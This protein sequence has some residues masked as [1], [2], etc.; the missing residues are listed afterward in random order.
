MFVRHNTFDWQDPADFAFEPSPVWLDDDAMAVDGGSQTFL[1]NILLKSKSSLGDYRKEC[2]QKRKEVENAKRLRQSIRE[3]RDKRD[4]VEVVR[5]QFALQERLHECERQKITAEVEVSTIATVVGDLSIG[6][7]NHAFKSQ[8][9]KIPTNCDLCGERIWGLSAKGFDCKD[10][11]FTCHNKCE[12]KVPASC[13]GEVGKEDRKKLKVERQAS[14]QA[15]TPTQP[16]QNGDG[17]SDM[18]TIS[19]SDTVGSMNT[20]SSGFATSA[21]RSVSGTIKGPEEAPKVVATSGSRRRV[22]APPPDHYVSNGTNGASKSE[23]HGKMT[24]AYQQN[25]DGEISV[26]E[27]NEVTILEADGKDALLH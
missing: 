15:A 7:K 4:E 27:G 18:P 12:M 8:T 17:A 6:A 9:F 19:R 16:G 13:P 1:R 5:A 21:Q 24:Y 26:D 23:D 22:I 14:A 2:D 25:G 11:G 10:C 3:G 20:L